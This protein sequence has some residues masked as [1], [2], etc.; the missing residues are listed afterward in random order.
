MSGVEHVL[1]RE[2]FCRIEC[3]REAMS[4]WD[5]ASGRRTKPDV[6]RTRTEFFVVSFGGSDLCFKSFFSAVYADTS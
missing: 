6:L 5:S 2:N 3:V 1:I 4:N